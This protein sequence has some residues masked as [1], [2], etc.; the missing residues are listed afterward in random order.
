MGLDEREHGEFTADYVEMRR[1]A[2]D[3]YGE[4]PTGLR[5]GA[6]AP[7]GSIHRTTSRH[8]LAT[9]NEQV[10]EKSSND[11]EVVTEAQV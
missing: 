6:G 2:E 3:Y 1:H 4:V 11:K 10:Q 8:S 7:A 9:E 5:G